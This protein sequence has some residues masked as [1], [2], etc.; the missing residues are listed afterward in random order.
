MSSVGIVIGLILNVTLETTSSVAFIS[1]P[2]KILPNLPNTG[3]N[4]YVVHNTLKT[5][6]LTWNNKNVN[7]LKFSTRKLKDRDKAHLVIESSRTH[8]N[9]HLTEEVRGQG[10]LHRKSPRSWFTAL[11]I[12]LPCSAA[13]MTSTPQLILDWS[14]LLICLRLRTRNLMRYTVK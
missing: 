14:V 1:I 6:H 8:H 11:T 13:L 10:Q 12:N 9:H 7:Y 5:G 2:T 4:L 3:L